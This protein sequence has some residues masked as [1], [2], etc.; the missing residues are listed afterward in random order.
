MNHPESQKSDSG[1]VRGNAWPSCHRYHT[2]GFRGG[3]NGWQDEVV[4]VVAASAPNTSTMDMELHREIATR[5]A[6]EVQMLNVEGPLDLHVAR[7][8]RYKFPE[9]LAFQHPSPEKDDH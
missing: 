6:A 7:K 1:R 8:P 9:L 3:Q 2:A 4:T 5:N